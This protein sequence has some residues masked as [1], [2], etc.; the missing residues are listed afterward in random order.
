MSNGFDQDRNVNTIGPLQNRVIGA[1][2]LFRKRPQRH[3]PKFSAKLLV[4]FLKGKYFLCRLE[5]L[6]KSICSENNK[7]SGRV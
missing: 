7:P 6:N 5:L 4:K 1:P 2:V 3:Q